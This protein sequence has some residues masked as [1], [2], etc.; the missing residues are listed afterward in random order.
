M[1]L[2]SR[3][4]ILG[5]CTTS[6]IEPSIAPD[7]PITQN[8][9]IHFRYFH[10]PV[11]QFQNFRFL[12]E[13]AAMLKHV[14]VALYFNKVFV[15]RFRCDMQFFSGRKT[16]FS[17]VNRFEIRRYVELRLAP[18]CPRNISKSE[19]MGSKFVRITSTI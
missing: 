13:S 7:I 2:W 19:K 15:G 17:A 11:L 9:Q 18:N 16:P 10:R 12:R 1:L 3:N 14:L 6:G 5:R 8:I 4:G